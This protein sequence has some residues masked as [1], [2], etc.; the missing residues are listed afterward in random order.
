V[1]ESK[2]RNRNSQRIAGKDAMT[3]VGIVGGTH[4]TGGEP[5]ALHEKRDAG[6]PSST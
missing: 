3:R 6:D 1:L 4:Y 2:Q 5:Q